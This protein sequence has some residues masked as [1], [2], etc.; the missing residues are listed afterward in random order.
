MPRVGWQTNDGLSNTGGRGQLSNQGCRGGDYR[1]RHVY[2]NSGSVLRQVVSCRE[3]GCLCARDYFARASREL[4]V[5][6]KEAKAVAGESWPRYDVY[7]Q[8]IRGKPHSRPGQGHCRNG[9]AGKAICCYRAP[10][11]TDHPHRHRERIAGRHLM[12]VRMLE[13][14]TRML[15]DTADFAPRRSRGLDGAGCRQ[16]RYRL[17]AGP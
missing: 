4:G 13:G 1:Q 7:S 10:D 9:L 3:S 6:L 14:M 11:S 15:S 2:P 16:L 5:V 8:G 17:F 12:S